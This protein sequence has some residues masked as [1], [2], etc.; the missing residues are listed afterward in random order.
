L[1]SALDYSCIARRDLQNSHH[2]H[3]HHHHLHHLLHHHHH[4]LLVP[5]ALLLRVLLLLRLG[6]L[7]D[8]LGLHMKPDRTDRLDARIKQEVTDIRK[9][10]HIKI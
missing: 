1:P 4:N 10:R 7:E 5:V 8:Q 9:Y 6:L 2:L 3:H